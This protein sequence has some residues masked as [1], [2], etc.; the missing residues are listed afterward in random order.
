MLASACPGWI[1]YAEKTHGDF[2]LPYISTTRSPQQVMG[3]LVKGYFAEQ[4]NLTPKQ[5]YHVTV[6]PC[7]DK[8]LEASRSD[9][10]LKEADTKRWTVSSRQE[11]L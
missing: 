4:H 9:F 8:K 7:F 6:M 5:I 11:R 10:F 2:I 3:S 1:C